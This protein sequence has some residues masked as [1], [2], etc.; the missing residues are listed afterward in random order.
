MPGFPR[1]GRD[2]P[3]EKKPEVEKPRE[4]RM[5]LRNGDSISGEVTGIEDGRILVQTPFRDVRLPLESLRSL[6]L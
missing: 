6:N 5:E 2:Q 1:F 3:E 4:G